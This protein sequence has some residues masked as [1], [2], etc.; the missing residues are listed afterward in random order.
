M[1]TARKGEIPEGGVS[2]PQKKSL[3]WLTF[4][5]PPNRGNLSLYL[6]SGKVKGLKLEALLIQRL[7]FKLM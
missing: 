3:T 6:F 4:L 5:E 2:E 7:R 1:S